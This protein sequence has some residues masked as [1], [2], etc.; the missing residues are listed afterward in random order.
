[1]TAT[2][3]GDLLLAVTNKGTGAPW[4]SRLAFVGGSG[5]VRLTV[6]WLTR[7]NPLTPVLRE[8]AELPRTVF[9]GD[10]VDVRLRLTPTSSGGAVLPPGDYLVRIGLVQDG[11][12]YFVDKGDQTLDVPVTVAA[13]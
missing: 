9:P 5:W 6:S 13:R 10:T 7:A 8:A 11:F 1:M 2:R 12:S 3:H 4:A